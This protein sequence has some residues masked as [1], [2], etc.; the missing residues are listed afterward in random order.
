[1][2]LEE[3]FQNQPEKAEIKTCDYAPP[4]SCKF[5]PPF[6]KT[7]RFFIKTLP[8]KPN[9]WKLTSAGP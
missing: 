9:S 4:P 8:V 1:M 6:G 5:L 2:A 7:K 3:P